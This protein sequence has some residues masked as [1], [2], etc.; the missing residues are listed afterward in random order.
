MEL[1]TVVNNL[2][3]DTQNYENVSRGFTAKIKDKFE[4]VSNFIIIKDSK[5]IRLFDEKNKLLINNE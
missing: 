1:D 2:R 3:E 5:L 4:K